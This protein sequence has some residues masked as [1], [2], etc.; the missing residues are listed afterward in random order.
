MKEAC[1]IVLKKLKLFLVLAPVYVLFV[2][3]ILRHTLVGTYTKFDDL[4]SHLKINSAILEGSSLGDAKDGD[5]RLA[6][7]LP[8]RKVLDYIKNEPFS[9][10]AVQTNDVA[11]L[12]AQAS[13]GLPIAVNLFSNSTPLYAHRPTVFVVTVLTGDMWLERRLYLR[14]FLSD[15]STGVQLGQ[16]VIW[17]EKQLNRSMAAPHGSQI[18]WVV[19]ED[20]AAELSD[21][22]L[23]FINCSRIPFAYF[24]A[25]PLITSAPSLG[26]EQN[27]KD[28]ALLFIASLNFTSGGNVVTFMDFRSLYSTRLLPRLAQIATESDTKL[29]NSTHMFLWPIDNIG[30]NG[31]SHPVFL[32]T[33]FSHWDNGNLYNGSYQPRLPIP[34]G[35]FGLTANFLRERL[36]SNPN[37]QR[38][39][40]HVASIQGSVAKQDEVDLSSFS[41]LDKLFPSERSYDRIHPIFEN[42]G[43]PLVW[44]KQPVTEREL[45]FT[46]PGEQAL[47]ENNK[48]LIDRVPWYEETNRTL[49]AMYRSM[50]LKKR[51]P[52]YTLVWK[53]YRPPHKDDKDNKIKKAE[54]NSAKVKK[55]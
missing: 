11:R 18:M 44:W 37:D 16:G 40:S 19:V 8:L 17:P 46:C 21:D 22:S 3:V 49:R 48:I 1:L 50:S 55:V 34:Y 41:L 51:P 13:D 38:Y 20:D 31:S 6:N 32:K 12:A 45:F 30:T 35:S 39:L 27:S 14:R 43:E 10:N 24:A 25:K 5:V 36:P 42:N 23:H 47:D 28:R 52:W 2:N 4:S 33:S 15:L 7:R 54:D 9:S 29:L 26:R 53:P